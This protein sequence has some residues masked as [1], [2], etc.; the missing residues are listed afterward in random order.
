MPSLLEQALEDARALGAGRGWT[1]PSPEAIAEAERLLSLVADWRAPEVRAEPDGAIVLEWDAGEAGWLQLA[2]RG[3]GQLEHSAVI[4]GDEYTQ[5]EPFEQ[6]LTPWAQ[7]LLAKL[8]G[9]G[10]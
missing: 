10:Q 2:V 5:S 6:A 7:H 1:L 4:D 3:T 9:R 8:L